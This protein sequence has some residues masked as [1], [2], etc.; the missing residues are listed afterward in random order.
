MTPLEYSVLPETNE[1]YYGVYI[2][3]FQKHEDESK[4][5]I[6]DRVLFIPLIYMLEE[7][8][9]KVSYEEYDDGVVELNI[10]DRT[11]KCNKSGIYGEDGRRLPYRCRFIKDVLFVQAEFID[12]ELNISI[13]L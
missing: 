12:K 10:L 11:Y 7:I 13:T 2:D 6:E 9:E 8:E 3:G 5:Y 1:D 4:P